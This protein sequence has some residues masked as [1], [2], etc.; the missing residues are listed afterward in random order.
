MIKY[1]QIVKQWLIVLGWKKEEFCFKGTNLLD[2]QKTKFLLNSQ[3]TTLFEQL[4]GL[5]PRG[6][7]PEFILQYA[8][9]ARI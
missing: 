1:H 6:A 5:N 8:K 9:C 2:W 3:R 4:N 7:K